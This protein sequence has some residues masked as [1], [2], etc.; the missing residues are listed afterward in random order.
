MVSSK[1]RLL[2]FHGVAF[3]GPGHLNVGSGNSVGSEEGALL[4]LVLLKLTSSSGPSRA[5]TREKGLSCS[6]VGYSACKDWK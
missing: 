2:A 4:K 6:L 5:S 3:T 1:E